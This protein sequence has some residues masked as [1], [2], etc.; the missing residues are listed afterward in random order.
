MMKLLI[1]TSL[2]FDYRPLAWIAGLC[3]SLLV[4]SACHQENKTAET[5]YAVFVPYEVPYQYRGDQR[6]IAPDLLDLA[7]EAYQNKEF[8]TAIEKF[9]LFLA[10]HPQH[11]LSSFYVGVSYMAIGK[12]REAFPF[13]ILAAEDPDSD[14]K[15]PAQWYLSLVYLETQQLQQAK[16]ILTTLQDDE[17]YSKQARHILKKHPMML[18]DMEQLPVFS[19][20]E[21]AFLGDSVNISLY[22]NIDIRSG[23]DKDQLLIRFLEDFESSCILRLYDERGFLVHMERVDEVKKNTQISIDLTYKDTGDYSLLIQLQ[24]DRIFPYRIRI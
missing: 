2:I 8:D 9:E 24:K 20:E 14:F 23:N 6:V 22:K 17:V 10:E 19:I 15:T 21:N 18:C 13:L 5:A 1:S 4:I 7:M 12:Y 3:L 11:L 16:Q